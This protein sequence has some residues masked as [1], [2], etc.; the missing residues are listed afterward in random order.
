MAKTRIKQY[1][2]EEFLFKLDLSLFAGQASS[3][4]WRWRQTQGEKDFAQCS[5]FCGCLSSL[6][7][8]RK[9]CATLEEKEGEI[10]LNSIFRLSEGKQTLSAHDENIP[11][12]NALG[13][14][15]EGR[16]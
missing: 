16:S 12:P 3:C 13:C 2:R 8:G 1:L 11:F 14:V 6:P 9:I 10:Q 15:S 5:H 7:S 4:V